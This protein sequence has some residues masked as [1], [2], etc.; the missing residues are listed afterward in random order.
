MTHKT[1]YEFDR[2]LERIRNRLRQDKPDPIKSV[3]ITPRNFHSKSDS[4]EPINEQHILALRNADF[5]LFE[6]RDFETTTITCYK[7]ISPAQDRTNVIDWSFDVASEIHL[8]TGQVLTKF[9]RDIKVEAK[10][11]YDHIPFDLEFQTITGSIHLSDD[12]ELLWIE[13]G[14]SSEDSLKAGIHVDLLKLIVYRQH[15]RFHFRLGIHAG[16]NI[17]MI[18]RLDDG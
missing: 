5:I 11:L 13:D 4:F 15:L 7:D 14:L 12:I 6:I 18:K 17:R 1:R 9:D 2:T 10:F 3:S 8:S 16:S